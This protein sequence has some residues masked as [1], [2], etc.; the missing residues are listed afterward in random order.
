MLAAAVPEFD[1]GRVV[2]FCT[3]LGRGRMSCTTRGTLVQSGTAEALRRRHLAVCCDELWGKASCG[4]ACTV[5][6]RP[7]RHRLAARTRERIQG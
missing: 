1:S 6:T 7:K 5:V 3:T 2:V 4:Q